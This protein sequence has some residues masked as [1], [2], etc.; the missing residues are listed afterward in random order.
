MT[1]SLQWSVMA[2]RGRNSTESN[3]WLFKSSNAKERVFLFFSN[4]CYQL[5]FI[6]IF[7]VIKLDCFHFQQE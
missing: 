4:K 2:A 6:N 5:M 7:Y 1:P 3:T